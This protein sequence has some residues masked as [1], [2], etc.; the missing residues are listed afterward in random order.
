MSMNSSVRV[1]DNGSN[2]FA[3]LAITVTTGM[4]TKYL[5]PTVYIF[6]QL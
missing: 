4:G 1:T 5:F 6:T 3:R 2:D